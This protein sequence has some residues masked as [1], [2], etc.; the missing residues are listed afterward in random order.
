MLFLGGLHVTECSRDNSPTQV[1]HSFCSTR[2]R[3]FVLLQTRVP[4]NYCKKFINKTLARV[5][6]CNKSMIRLVY[7]IFSFMFTFYDSKP[8]ISLHTAYLVKQ[9]IKTSVLF[10]N[11][12]V[13]LI[14]IL[15]IKYDKFC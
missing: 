1:S 8:K 4:L 13:M 3:K 10:I 6:R 5:Q 14:L 9:P 7:L 2:E 12:V 11:M 15:Q